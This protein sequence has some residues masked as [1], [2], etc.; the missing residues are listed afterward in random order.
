MASID[1][2]MIR[3]ERHRADDAA[4]AFV[5]GI[6]QFASPYSNIHVLV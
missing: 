3:R 6:S 5:S 1:M 2:T 4:T